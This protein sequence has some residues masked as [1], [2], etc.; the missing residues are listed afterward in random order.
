MTSRNQSGFQCLIYLL[1]RPPLKVIKMT[2]P[3]QKRQRKTVAEIFNTPQNC[4]KG[5]NSKV[6]HK[7][8][9]IGFIQYNIL[10]NAAT[11]NEAELLRHIRDLLKKKPDLILAPEIFLG[12]PQNKARFAE[13]AKLYRSTIE[14]LRI[15]SKK[16]GCHF[17]GSII[18]DSGG[19]FYNTAIFINSKGKAATVYRKKHLFRFDGEHRL[20]GAGRDAAVFSAPWGKTAPQ[21]C[22]DIRFPELLRGMVFSGAKI[23]LVAAQW[24]DSRSDHWLTL[25]KARAIENQIYVLACNRTGTKNQLTYGGL[26]CAISPWG[27]FLCLFDSNH[28]TG[29]VQIDL[30]LITTVRK[31]YPFLKDADVKSS[32]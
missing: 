20:F 29:F 24:P 18:E 32:F 27:E 3:S 9:K 6:K 10:Q 13:T 15:L 25:L 4:R 14:K 1:I 30:S 19:T 2:V 5:I 16:S 31:R 22:Y 8:L 12:S 17:Y 11:D 7:K 28:Q 26:S 23:V 21:I